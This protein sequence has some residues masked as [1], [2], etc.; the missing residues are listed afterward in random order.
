MSALLYLLAYAAVIACVAIM[1]MKIAGYLQKPLHLRWE[2]YPVPHE[3]KGRAA[4]GGSYLEDADWYTHKQE[5]SLAG[6]LKGFLMEALFLHATR[7]HNRELWLRT[8]PFHVGLYLLLGSLGLTVLS[9]MSALA[10]HS[11]WFFKLC[12]YLAA[13]G[14]LLGF[15]GVLLGS[16]GLIQRRLGKPDL[17]KFSTNEHFF[18]LG[19][20][21][22]W[23]ALGLLLCL[24]HGPLG[25]TR[26]GMLFIAGM[27]SVETAL[28]CTF[29]YIL[30]LLLSFFIFIWVPVSFMGH[31]Y[32]KYFTWHDIRW[33]DEPTQDNPKT[34]AALMKN[35]GRPMSW[36]A[37]HIQGDGKMTWAEMAT[38]PPPARKEDKE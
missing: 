25:F 13:L 21:A 15:I 24:A 1:A 30:Y 17:R 18:N 16:V 38:T 29:L 8:Y 33:G 9:A 4:Y 19:L 27:L 10:G 3:V 2:L 14:N 5:H 26:E 20:F 6:T 23:S 11:G 28:S 35:L 36:S 22:L 7:E 34:Q 12:L 31:A 32:M 37:P